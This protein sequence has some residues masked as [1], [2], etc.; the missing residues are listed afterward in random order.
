M[1]TSICYTCI[2]MSFIVLNY[3][4]FYLYAVFIMFCETL[5][6]F[7]LA[8]FAPV[9]QNVPYLYSYGYGKWFTFPHLWICKIT[10]VGQIKRNFSSTRKEWSKTMLNL[11]LLIFNKNFSIFFLLIFKGMDRILLQLNIY[12]LYWMCW[13]IAYFV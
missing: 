12:H 7:I 3:L 8:K 6:L 9:A 2:D 13:P 5:L 1:Q 11:R 10:K 4:Y